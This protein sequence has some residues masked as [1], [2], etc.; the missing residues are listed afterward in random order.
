ML[1]VAVTTA[2]A[3]PRPST[4]AGNAPPKPVMTTINSVNPNP[5]NSRTT[6]AY[7]LKQAGR[8]TIKVFDAV[9]HELQTL[10]DEH[11]AAGKHELEIS[12]KIFTATGS[13]FC[14]IV[15]ENEPP[16]SCSLSFQK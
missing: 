10:F 5:F 9:G 8:V 14:S 2:H 1:F 6:V 16:V 15:W 4:P 12:G 11:A 13:Y 7:T 3:Q